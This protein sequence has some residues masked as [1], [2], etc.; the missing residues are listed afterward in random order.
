MQD[1]GTVSLNWPQ[2]I[3]LLL[4]L[5]AIAAAVVW[6]IKKKK[7]AAAPTRSGAAPGVA[8]RISAR[9]TDS[10]KYRQR[11]DENYDKAI[12]YEW[13]RIC[14]GVKN[15]PDYNSV[16]RRLAAA[17]AHAKITQKNAAASLGISATTLS[18]YEN[19]STPP[20]QVLQA[21][22][23]LYGVPAAFLQSGWILPLDEHVRLCQICGEEEYLD[24]LVVSVRAA[25]RMF[26][27]MLT[28]EDRQICRDLIARFD[29]KEKLP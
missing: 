13:F 6:F 9:E 27:D 25:C 2:T 28:E 19:G 21:A 3:V 29:L 11:F 23:Q 14:T 20:A 26:P 1:P 8:V 17:R 4:V 10:G 16:S 5:V 18:T 12:G 24:S 7:G 22:A 15:Y